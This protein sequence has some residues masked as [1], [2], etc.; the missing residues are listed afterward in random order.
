MHEGGASA[1]RSAR[2]FV[3]RQ[4]ELADLTSALEDAALGQGSLVLLTG[5]PGIGKTRLMAELGRMAGQRGFSVVAGRCWEEGGAPPY[6]PWIQVLRSVGGDFEQLAGSAHP[7]RPAAAGGVRPEGE[8]LRLFDDVG[9]FLAAASSSHP[10]VVT[11]DDVHAADEPSLLLLRFL[12]EALVDKAILLV[13][14]YRDGERRVRELGELFG[15]LARAGL[16]L[17]LRG[18]TSVEIEAYVSTATGSAPTHEVVSRLHE[19]TGGNPFFVG[20][21]VRLLAAEDALA[22]LDQPIRDPLLRVPEEVRGLIRRRVASLPAEAVG[23]LRIAAVLG[24]EFELHLL[25]RMSRLTPARIL[26]VIREAIAIGVVG[27]SGL[28]APVLVC[29]RARARDPLRRP[30]PGTASRAAPGGGPPARVRLR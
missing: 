25:R 19:I 22:R 30:A 14:S 13:A 24:R 9:R 23:V 10:L 7:T 15:E 27:A 28:A 6:W 29:P 1:A 8:R 11:L 12:G 4:E 20:E 17:P 16:R 18:L 3:G 26:E 21:V 2:F 5:E